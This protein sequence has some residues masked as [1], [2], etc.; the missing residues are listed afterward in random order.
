MAMVQSE[1]DLLSQLDHRNVV[2]LLG[3]QRTLQSLNILM[4]YISGK[5]LDV[6]LENFGAFDE[7]VLKNYSRMLCLALQHC[8]ER[9][10]IHRDLK[11][12][13]V[14][15]DVDGQIKLCDFG[16]AKQLQSL[17]SK[18][19]PTASYN[20]TPL[21]TAPEVMTCS[22]YDR[23]VDIWS[24]GCVIIEMTTAK[25]PWSE[26][27]FP[28]PFSALFHIGSCGSIPKFPETLS[29][30]CKDFLRACLTRYIH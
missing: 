1:V 29:G 9:G 28:S 10:I 17:T 27:E 25:M 16:S 15:V 21:W 7:P 8:H 20:Y 13:N 19:A 3:T 24:L 22:T 11:G 30:N 2:K 12:K 23:K 4:E 18:E 6:L 14:L 5:S 26:C